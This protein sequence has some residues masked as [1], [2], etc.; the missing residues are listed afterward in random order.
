MTDQ[1]TLPTVTLPEGQ[2]GRWTVER[3]SLSAEECARAARCAQ[4]VFIGGK[5]RFLWRATPTDEPGT[6]TRLLRDGQVIMSDTPV[7]RAAYQAVVAAAQGHVHISGLGLGAVALACLQKPEVAH[8]TV[9]EQSPDVLALVGTHY[10]ER[11]GA[12]R[13]TLV[14]G[15]ARTYEPP[16]GAIYG[17][18]WHDI[19]D[20]IDPR[21]LPEMAALHARFAGRTAWQGSW[22]F[23][24]CERLVVAGWTPRDLILGLSDFS[25]EALAVLRQ[26]CEVL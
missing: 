19:W 16:Q 8:V 11:F 9:V 6:Y 17:A 25:L 10:R 26:R 18:V 3:F 1:L 7:E 13:L 24:A 22:S 20:E 12:A 15:D 23:E 21:N 2:S 14:L 5:A 4:L